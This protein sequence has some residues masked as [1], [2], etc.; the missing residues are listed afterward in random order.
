[1]CY[2]WIFCAAETLYQTN[3]S[4]DSFGISKSNNKQLLKFPTIHLINYS[5]ARISKF[6]SIS[7]VFTRFPSSHFHYTH[8]THTKFNFSAT[9][10]TSKSSKNQLQ[11]CKTFIIYFLIKGKFTREGNFSFIPIE[12]LT[13]TEPTSCKRNEENRRERREG[14]HMKTREKLGERELLSERETIADEGWNQD[15]PKHI[16]YIPNRCETFSSSSSLWNFPR[17]VRGAMERKNIFNFSSNSIIA[18][19]SLLVLFVPFLVRAKKLFRVR[20]KLSF[21]PHFWLDH[22][23]L[24]MMNKLFHFLIDLTWKGRRF[25]KLLMRKGWSLKY[26]NWKFNLVTFY[27]LF[28]FWALRVFQVDRN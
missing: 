13:M 23:W 17:H 20:W 16:V 11:S 7:L 12:A 26:A 18:S 3:N 28:I 25:V 2:P 6:S 22:R 14:K 24:W 27:M 8:L 19:H 15:F 9:S 5:L 1:M 21:L 4:L 10:K